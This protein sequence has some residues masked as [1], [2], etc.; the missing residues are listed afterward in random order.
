VSVGNLTV[1]GSGKTPTVCHLAHLLLRMGERPSILSRGYGRRIVSDDVVIVSNGERVLGDLDR[2]GDE[3][4]MLARAV[5]GAA[6]VV[7][8][9]RH[10][11][12]LVAEETLGCTVHILDDGFQH[13]KLDRDVDL[14]LVSPDDVHE[15]PLP[16][17]RLREP[18][19]AASGADALLVHGT[20]EDAGA[21]VRVLGVAEAFQVIRETRPLRRVAPFGEPWEMPPRSRVIAAA[22]IARP[23]RFFAAVGEQGWTIAGEA[24]FRDHHRYSAS[25]VAHLVEMARSRQAVAIVT[26]EKDAIRLEPHAPFAIPIVWLPIE[27]TIEPGASFRQWLALRLAS[28]TRARLEAR[29]KAAGG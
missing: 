27:L 24:R 5:P 10:A 29:A 28:A 22:G 14:L 9:E 3:P 21:L 19:T 4:L 11:A 2:A 17:G 20:S 15:T 1:G 6:V 13:M 12:G 16:S 8:P 23:E 26:T 18:L 7:A 25:D